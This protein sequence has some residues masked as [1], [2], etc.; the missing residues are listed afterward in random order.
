MHLAPNWHGDMKQR[1]G[2]WS[3]AVSAAAFKASA[4]LSGDATARALLRHRFLFD[5]PRS[6]SIDR[7]RRELEWL[8]RSFSVVTVPDF[9]A[10]LT[11]GEVRDHALTF[12][13]DD[14]H[15]DI[16]EVH[17]EFRDFG[18]P[19]CMFVPIGWV[20]SS[21]GSEAGS[22]LEA[23][24][25]VQWYEGDPV[26]ISFGRDNALYLAAERRSNNV[27]WLIEN[28]DVVTPYLEELCAKIAV[29]PGS[30]RQRHDIRSTCNWDELHQLAAAGVH[31]A[32]HSV[33]HPR[34]ATMSRAR[35]TFE[36]VES[37][38][39]IESRFGP[40]TAF[41]YP[42]G[43]ADS[44]DSSTARAL[45]DAGYLAAFLSHSDVIGTSTPL[46][47]LP[48]IT[49]PD[50]AIPLEEFRARVHGGGILP[51]RLR[52]ALGAAKRFRPH[53]RST[54]RAAHRSAL[55]AQPIGEFASQNI[56]A[57]QQLKRL[58][59]ESC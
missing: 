20:S 49:I 3:W 58:S 54:P 48:R 6:K 47:E 9:I 55:L 59:S 28:R 22:L 42:Y 29:L 8:R 38:R 11:R 30:H 19:L 35:Q 16:F 2:S 1:L 50:V 34:M 39:A 44:Y 52:N 51:Q 43:T 7:L 40:C 56:G 31:I 33:S 57:V 4:S 14:V 36:A 45:S 10:A 53:A 12:T 32:P 17:E 25:L 23:V 41:A 46:F 13:T 21:D 37:K 18:V 15:L 24:T 5:E 26:S 27:D